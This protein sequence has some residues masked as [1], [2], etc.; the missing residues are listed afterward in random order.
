[1]AFLHNDREQF[2][3]AIGITA[4]QT[5]V[6]AQAVEKDYYFITQYLHGN[7]LDIRLCLERK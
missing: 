3:E 5:G 4:Y 2:G 7:I 6:M 1:M